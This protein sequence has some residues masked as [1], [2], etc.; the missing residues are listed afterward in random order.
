MRTTV[1]LDDRLFKKA[2]QRAADLGT[3]LSEVL[4]HALRL[5]LAQ[6]PTRPARSRFEMITFG[7]PTRPTSHEPADFAEMLDGDDVRSLARPRNP[8]G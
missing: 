1:M 5:S 4:N 8:S 2:K 3:S 6:E 7:D